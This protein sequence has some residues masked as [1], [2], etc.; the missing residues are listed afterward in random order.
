MANSV[1][2]SDEAFILSQV[3]KMDPSTVFWTK[4]QHSTL[5][6][7]YSTAESF[8][9]AL[10]GSKPITLLAIDGSLMSETESRET[11]ADIKTNHPDTH[12]LALSIRYPRTESSCLTS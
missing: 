4:L 7:R 8:L 10:E 9:G 1:T 5:K 6:C 12:H 11:F 2:R 3:P